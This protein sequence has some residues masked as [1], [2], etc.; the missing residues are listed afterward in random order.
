M[1]EKNEF[2]N[3]TNDGG[4]K[5]KIL[6]EGKGENQMKG[7]VVRIKYKRLDEKFLMKK[8]CKKILLQLF[9]N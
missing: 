4:L 9:S 7:S 2:I 8:Y 6:I 5:K 1:S 3:I